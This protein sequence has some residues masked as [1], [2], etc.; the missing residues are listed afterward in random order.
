MRKHKR[1]VCLAGRLVFEGLK[2]S[3]SCPLLVSA[4]LEVQTGCGWCVRL[5]SFWRVRVVRH[6]RYRVAQEGRVLHFTLSHQ[7][8]VE[9]VG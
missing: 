9:A 2:R 5:S 6:A 8:R 1:P 4:L 7:L 3:V